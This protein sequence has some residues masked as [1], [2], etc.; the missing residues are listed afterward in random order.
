MN[1]NYR[2]TK[3]VL[4][5]VLL[6]FFIRATWA[7][8]T[9]AA[10]DTL[11]EAVALREMPMIASKNFSRSM[12]SDRSWKHFIIKGENRKK[13]TKALDDFGSLS[14]KE[15]QS[16]STIKRAILQIQLW[17]VFDWTVDPTSYPARHPGLE[18]EKAELFE[19]QNKLASLIRRIALSEEQIAA[20]P[21][22]Y[23]ATVESKKF[24]VTY[25]SSSRFNPFFPSDLRNDKGP[26]V[27]LI[28][29][30]HPISA[31]LHTEMK[32][33]RSAFHIYVR[34]PGTRED[35]LSYIKKLGD[36]RDP[37]VTEK[38]TTNIN[39]RTTPHGGINYVNIY[40]NPK[41]PQ[42]P[43]GTQFSLVEQALLISDAGEPVSSPL[44]TKVQVRAYLRVDLKKPEQAVAEFSIQLRKLMKGNATLRSTVSAENLTGGGDLTKNSS[45]SKPEGQKRISC[46][47]C[48]S[49]W[50]IHS[51]NSRAQLFEK[52]TLE[53]P[54]FYEA[55][56]TWT[57]QATIRAK[58]KN[59]SW[60]LLQGLWRNQKASGSN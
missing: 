1:Q 29:Y 11:Y 22:T 20:L 10:F 60:G 45:G 5:T 6:L 49:G 28:K 41:T 19:L 12:V 34:L 18:Y 2:K 37:W 43:V 58:K 53:P 30:T 40:V 50:G 23:A 55:D 48:H 36:F 26:W 33:W 32:Q 47:A 7:E 57:N 4:V 15:I 16:I 3:C 51:V 56:P 35:T 39:Q 27:L 14:R 25:D 42:F 38:P 9:A 59:F 24:P 52:R 8:D 31:K 44:T 54:R 46:I 21:D 13:Y 17:S